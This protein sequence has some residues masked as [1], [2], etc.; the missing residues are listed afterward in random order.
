M[1]LLL[2]TLHC[3]VDA[4]A[5]GSVLEL[6]KH[7]RGE[8]RKVFDAG[9]EIEREV[10]LPPFGLRCWKRELAVKTELIV[11]LPEFQFG[12]LDAAVHES[13]S[14]DERVPLAGFPLEIRRGEAQGSA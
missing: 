6:R 12:H 11:S 8:F 14:H 4:D 7:E 13:R 3:T 2:L 5:S 10:G 1:E 9:R